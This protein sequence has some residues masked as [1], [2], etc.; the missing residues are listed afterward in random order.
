M[1]ASHLI[2]FYHLLLQYCVTVV[3]C[4]SRACL[5][6]FAQWIFRSSES[7][8]ILRL[9]PCQTRVSTIQNMQILISNSLTSPSRKPKMSG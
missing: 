1:K 6:S 5:L 8:S 9:I 4:R 3:V 2:G 7:L